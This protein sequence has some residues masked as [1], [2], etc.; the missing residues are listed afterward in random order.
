M[1]KNENRVKPIRFTA[2]NGEVYTLEFSRDTVRFAEQRGFMID[3][4]TAY[5]Q[6]NIPALWYFAFRMHHRNVARSQ[7]DAMLDSLGGLTARELERLVQ[8][9]N[10]TFESLIVDEGEERKNSKV[11]M[12][13]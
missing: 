12:E 11:T 1:A 3:E 13:L 5:P 8:L 9:Y 7:S 10:Q 2:E 4:L 6:T